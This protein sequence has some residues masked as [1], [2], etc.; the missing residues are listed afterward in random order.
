MTILIKT[1]SRTQLESEDSQE[2]PEL[3]H[4]LVFIILFPLCLHRTRGSVW[5]L[6]ESYPMSKIPSGF[7]R[8]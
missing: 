8:L 7:E 4:S 6:A 2:A 3:I 1:E 5:R